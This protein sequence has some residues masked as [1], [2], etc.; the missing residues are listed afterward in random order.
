LTPSRDSAT[1]RFVLPRTA[2]VTVGALVLATLVSACMGT[3]TSAP[4]G[5][6]SPPVT[7]SGGPPAS[8]SGAQDSIPVRH[9]PSSVPA[10]L[11]AYCG[12]HPICDDFATPSGNIRCFAWARLGGSID[13]TMGTPLVPTPKTSCEEDV[14]GLAMHHGNA[15]APDCRGDPTPAGLDRHIPSLPYNTAWEGFGL[16]CVSRTVGLTCSD[17]EGHG[18]FLSRQRWSAR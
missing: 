7:S 10:R 4:E 11:V 1:V 16:R 2:H 18:F 12:T 14:V 13:C 15:A 8:T 5:G 3:T 17:G 6:S 9:A